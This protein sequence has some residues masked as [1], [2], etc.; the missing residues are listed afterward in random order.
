[1]IL[2]L[3]NDV[4]S[5]RR[6]KMR[7]KRKRPECAPMYI[8][9]KG[10]VCVKLSASVCPL[11]PPRSGAIWDQ[12]N[13]RW[14]ADA[15]NQSSIA[16]LNPAARLHSFI[17]T[18]TRLAEREK[19]SGHE[20]STKETKSHLVHINRAALSLSPGKPIRGESAP[21]RHFQP[22]SEHI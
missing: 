14:N 5:S 4:I 20:V 9:D 19:R 11:P 18:G 3:G 15:G 13:H 10:C 6:R 17:S 1:M 8:E 21:V 7:E 16:R 2:C 22:F 12:V